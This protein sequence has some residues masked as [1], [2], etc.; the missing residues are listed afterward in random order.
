[1]KTT[2]VLLAAGLGLGAL[3]SRA[4]ADETHLKAVA[5]SVF[6]KYQDAVTTVK[7]VI[8]YRFLVKGKEISKSESVVEV[9]GTVLTPAGLTV[10]SNA[11]MKL[12]LADGS[13]P[14]IPSLDGETEGAKVEVD[15]GAVKLVF[16][17]G[18]EIPG[19]FVLTDKDLDLDF[20]MPTERCDKVPHVHLHEGQIPELLDDLI[21]LNRTG[22]L[23]NHSPTVGLRT[24]AGVVHKP[25]TWVV[26]DSSDTSTL[27][28]P[29]FDIRGRLVG[30]GV[31]R[32]SA[33]SG[34]RGDPIVEP[35]NIVILTAADVQQVASQVPSDVTGPKK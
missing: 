9:F 8:T 12:N 35:D 20:V 30:I 17:G 4:P 26:L 33:K 34:S 28:C 23:L 11:S 2:L 13:L 31:L 25:R 21:V 15:R 18:R 22:K 24:V 6:A 27:G 16:K 7:A 1:M 14:A 32:Q 10:V 3:V 19:R 5:K 29:F